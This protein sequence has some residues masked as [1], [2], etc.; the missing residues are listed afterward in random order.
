[1]SEQVI[2]FENIDNNENFE[3]SEEDKGFDF[4]SYEGL[5]IKNCDILID[6]FPIKLE[7]E[8]KENLKNTIL[9]FYKENQNNEL[10]TIKKEFSY[11][12][13]DKQYKCKFLCFIKKIDEETVD[14]KYRFNEIDISKVG[15][16]EDVSNNKDDKND[17][18]KKI[19][20]IFGKKEQI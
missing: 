15:N 19:L 1:M 2:L 18:W 17:C 10:F 16:F 5:K 12:R 13:D 7:K 4:T 11:I 14:I 3:E 20:S 8:E 9:D 6:S